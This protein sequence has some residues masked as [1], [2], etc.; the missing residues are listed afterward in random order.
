MTRSHVYGVLSNL[1]AMRSTSPVPF[2]KH[3]LV[4]HF[5]EEIINLFCNYFLHIINQNYAINYADVGFLISLNSSTCFQLPER[6]SLLRCGKKK[7][8]I[9]HMEF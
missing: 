1:F 5:A 4:I 8:R 3:L 7:K 9:S 2:V 6:V